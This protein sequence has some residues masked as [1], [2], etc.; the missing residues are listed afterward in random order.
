VVV[1]DLQNRHVVFRHV[2]RQPEFDIGAAL[3]LFRMDGLD[4]A[5]ADDFTGGRF[6]FA[7]RPLDGRT[8]LRQETGQREQLPPHRVTRI[9]PPKFGIQEILECIK[10]VATGKARRV[11]IESASLTVGPADPSRDDDVQFEIAA[12]RMRR[13]EYWGPKWLRNTG[14]SNFTIQPQNLLYRNPRFPRPGIERF[15]VDVTLCEINNQR[16]VFMLTWRNPDCST[17][18][19]RITD[20]NF[21]RRNSLKSL[22]S[23]AVRLVD[24]LINRISNRVGCGTYG[25]GKIRGRQDHHSSGPSSKSLP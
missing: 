13:N 1:G 5:V 9:G 12:V 18:Q 2:F 25:V 4:N 14:E 10:V 11:G 8:L 3:D 19:H 23:I 17:H 15:N 6:P 20:K 16:P 7:A 22:S 21:R 24:N